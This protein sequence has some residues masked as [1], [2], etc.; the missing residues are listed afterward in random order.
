MQWP[1][2]A[3][4]LHVV[5]AVI[6]IAGLVGRWILLTRASRADEV[7]TPTCSPSRQRHSNGW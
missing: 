5:V 7:E 3:T 6:F 2:L 4:L 1:L